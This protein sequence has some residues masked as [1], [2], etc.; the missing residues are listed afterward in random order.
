I[1]EKTES[2]ITVIQ[3]AIKSIREVRSQYNIPPKVRLKASAKA[4]A[5]ISEILNT[6]SDLLCRLAGLEEFTAAKEM[7]KPSKAA[8]A[9]VDEIQIFV[10]D[11]I[12]PDAERN[13]LEKQKEQIVKG[14][15]GTESKLNNE[16]FIS[17]A[18]PEVVEQAKAKLKEF[19]DQLAAI[20]KHIAEIED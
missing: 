2:D 5:A 4:P 1:C 14:L 12:D 15:L 18:K 20:E 7:E 17:R 6:N 3:N 9:I 13:R 19:Q 8:S 10:H 16:N 11:V